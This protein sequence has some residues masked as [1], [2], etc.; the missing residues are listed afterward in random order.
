[1]QK[2]PNRF[3][4]EL[5]SQPWS[6][7]HA[8]FRDYCTVRHPKLMEAF[9]E[10]DHFVRRPSERRIIGLV[11]PTGAGKTKLKVMLVKAVIERLLPELTA[12]PGRVPIATFSIWGPEV[13]A[14]SWRDLYHCYLESMDEVLITHKIARVRKNLETDE[15]DADEAI[16]AATKRPVTRYR[17][18]TTHDLRRTVKDTLR[19]RRPEVT[20]I[21]EGQHLMKMARDG[22]RLSQQFDVLKSLV[23]QTR[24]P[25]ILI[26]PY[27]LVRFLDIHGQLGRRS[28]Y[29][30]LPRYDAQDG[31]QLRQFQSVVAAFQRLLPLAEEPDLLKHYAFLYERSLG[32]VGILK[33]LLEDALF[34]ALDAGAPRLS[35]AHLKKAGMPPTKCRQILREIK[36]G[37]KC[38]EEDPKD[39][40]LLLAELGL[41]P[42][43]Q[44]AMNGQSEVSVPAEDSPTVAQSFP[45][46]PGGNPNKR[47]SPGDR[48]PVRDPV[49]LPVGCE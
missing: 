43:L 26:G 38:V 23:D 44:V 31:K 37:E 6:A 35:F 33:S 46:M 10:L 15:R 49:G 22:L 1:M 29:V 40:S 21:D 17:L 27:E 45:P 11:G 2:E 48:N 12:D 20:V 42:D 16:T 28:S 24:V 18:P 4:V 7:R 14:F 34:A 13:D 36:E 32:C 47:R 41:T 39:Q 19:H 25:H 8:Y 5:L 30:H 3:P 9:A